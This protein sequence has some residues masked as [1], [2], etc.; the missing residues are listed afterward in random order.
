MDDKIKSYLG[1]GWA[2]PPTFI[3]NVGVEMVSEEEDIRQSLQ[4]L[5]STTIGERIFRFDYGCNIKQF[6]F[7]EMNLSIKTLI[8]DHIKQSVLYFEPRIKVESIDIE[9]KEPLEGTLWINIEY[10]V[11]KTNN[12]SNM[13]YPFYFREGTNL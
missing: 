2:F 6:V 13:V 10:I 12:R 4:I 1:T 11:L 9:I 3:K 8:A 5:F 7:D